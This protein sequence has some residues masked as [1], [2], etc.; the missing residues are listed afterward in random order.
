MGM[1]LILTAGMGVGMTMGA[2]VATAQPPATPP[3]TPA[4]KPK[5][6][7]LNPPGADKGGLAD[8]P[9]IDQSGPSSV[10]I[11]TEARWVLEKELEIV[12]D[13]NSVTGEAVSTWRHEVETQQ[14]IKQEFKQT[15]ALEKPSKFY[16]DTRDVT[17]FVDGKTVTVYSKSLKQYVQRPMPD[18]WL[19]REMLEQLSSGQIRSIPGEA[20]LRPGMSLEQTLRGVRSVERLRNGD[21]EGESGTWVSGTAMDDRQPGSSP[22]TFERFYADSDHMV[23]CVKQNMTAMY[24]DMA[25]RMAA[26]DSE[27]LDVPK[28]ASKYLQVGTTTTYKRVL[29]AKI[30]ADRFTFTPGPEDRKVEKL[31]Y[32]IHP[33][34]KDQIAMIGKPA[35]AL[36]GKDFD[37]NVVDIPA[38]KGKVVVLD[39]WATWCGPCCA[40]LPSMQMIKEKYA[41]KPFV[42]IGMNREHAGDERK[43]KPFLARRNLNIQQFN[44]VEGKAAEAYITTNSIP[45]VIIID[46]Q[47]N[48][49]DIENGYLP[50]KEKELMAKLEKLFAGK[51]VHT[52]EELAAIREQVGLGKAN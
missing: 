31:L 42:L 6:P 3:S 43:V 32:L 49:A 29:N 4:E 12:K 40:S 14:P 47:G 10:D 48:V 45:C 41:D 23:H 17:A 39:F 18:L 44:D 11:W 35:P 30:P 27:G 38:M 7:A 22:F 13:L 19:L 52:P 8:R 16:M 15:Y 2:T 37:G 5:A 24:Q 20:I 1:A 36:V 28:K 46:Q 26:E 34:V 21:F 51:P 25:D 50:G 9:S 33:G